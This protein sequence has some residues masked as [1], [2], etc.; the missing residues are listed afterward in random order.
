MWGDPKSDW[1]PVA[2]LG[3]FA[4]Q[5]EKLLWENGRF[6]GVF[7]WFLVFFGSL[8]ILIT[9]WYHL[10][11]GHEWISVL[12]QAFLLW[13]SLGWKS[14]IE[15]TQN[16]TAATNIED[17]KVKVGMIVGRNTAQMNQQDI[18][19]ASIESLAE[20][21]SDA[22]IAPLFWFILLGGWGAWA[23][24]IINTLDAMWGY[25]NEKYTYF[26]WFTAKIDDIANFFPARI[27][28]LLMLLQQP[29]LLN[30]MPSIYHQAKQHLS[31]NAGFPETAMA[32]LLDIR[33]GGDVIRDTGVEHRACMGEHTQSITTTHIQQGILISNRCV[34]AML[35]L[36]YIGILY[37]NTMNIPW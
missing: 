15:H 31:P 5:I 30:K 21:T 33:L 3:N 10:A 35:S 23:Y 26:G 2:T 36:L 12:F 8:S 6:S 19:K 18:H 16:I 25:K 29:R 24:R 9:L 7:A 20:N 13:F 32:F 11:Y 22:I 1:H 4:S 17:A 14:L 37:T 28:A 34:Y 27:T